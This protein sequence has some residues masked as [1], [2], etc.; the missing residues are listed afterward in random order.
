MKSDATVIIITRLS[1]NC[2]LLFIFGIG[3]VTTTTTVAPAV[4]WVLGRAGQSCSQA[5]AYTPCHNG[6]QSAIASISAFRNII[7]IAFNQ[8]YLT[9][10]GTFYTDPT[11]A[12]ASSVPADGSSKCFLSAVAS[13]CD[14]VR[15]HQR[16]L[17]CC[18]TNA[19]PTRYVPSSLG[20]VLGV[21][22]TSCSDSCPDAS[23]VNT[24][25]MAAVTS[26]FAFLSVLSDIAAVT[27]TPTCS[28][29]NDA[30]SATEPSYAAS[31]GNCYLAFNAPSND[32]AYNDGRRVCCCK[33][34]GCPVLNRPL[35]I[36]ET[37]SCFNNVSGG[38]WVLVR[39]VKQG[40]VWHPALDD[41]EGSDVY[42]TYG[43]STSDSTFSVEFW[44][45]IRAG[46]EILFATGAHSTA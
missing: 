42:G 27:P 5:C 23:S 2:Y 31:T 44:P 32:S 14:A 40:S 37:F 13:T 19:C 15:D 22:G 24:T 46:T 43:S 3:F 18:G 4:G 28:S 41:L 29:F 7:S 25:S 35:R 36:P 1:I 11:S 45:W 30:V 33:P 6:S 17:C 20:W 26:K 21:K 39:R 34:G 9:S 8:S 12:A 38:G 10:C 16:R